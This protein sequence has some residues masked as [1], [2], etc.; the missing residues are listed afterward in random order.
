M[1]S[2]GRVITESSLPSARANSGDSSHLFDLEWE[3]QPAAECDPCHSQIARRA[4][5]L[6]R[7][8]EV[9]CMTYVIVEP[10]VGEENASCVDVCPA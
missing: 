4:A 10:C 7:V 1:P 2:G 5:H 6:P 3:I 9:P 8:Q